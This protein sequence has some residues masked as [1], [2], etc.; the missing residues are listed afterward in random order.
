MFRYQ[1]GEPD[2]R[3]TPVTSSIGA[4]GIDNVSAVPIPAA[5][6]LLSGALAA[7]GFAGRRR[8]AD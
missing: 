1:T 7:L 2:S 5:V 4:F 3:G 6:W 8:T